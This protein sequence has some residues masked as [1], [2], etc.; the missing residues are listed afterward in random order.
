MR[1]H[2]KKS[3]IDAN[4]RT[5]QIGIGGSE[6]VHWSHLLIRGLRADISISA[7]IR[8]NHSLAPVSAVVANCG[9]LNNATDVK[10]KI[11][12]FRWDTCLTVVADLQ[13][14]VTA[15]AAGMIAYVVDTEGGDRFQVPFLGDSTGWK[16][17]FVTLPLR[18]GELLRQLVTQR[19]HGVKLGISGPILP[20]TNKFD[21]MASFSSS[22]PTYDGRIKPDLVA[23]GDSIYSADVLTDA[24]AASNDTCQKV[25]KDGSSMATPIAAGAFAP[26]KNQ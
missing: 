1:S 24:E 23:P 26:E 6:G 10:G 8:G 18:D 15:G 22:G 9:G 25:D 16:I 3:Q 2:E 17:P 4:I 13:E 7:P 14:L 20:P 11:V 12:I 5:W 19:S 21:N